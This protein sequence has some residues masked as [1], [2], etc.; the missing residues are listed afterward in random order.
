MTIDEAKA[1]ID[2]LS[3]R[4]LIYHFDEDAEDCLQGVVSE[5]EAKKFR[6]KLMQSTT[7]I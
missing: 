4:K 6:A 5:T 3:K 1:I 7:Q 2:D